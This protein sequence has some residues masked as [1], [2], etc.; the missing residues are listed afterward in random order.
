MSISPRITQLH[1]A[2]LND[3]THNSAE[4]VIA[5]LDERCEGSWIQLTATQDGSFTVVNSRN[6]FSKSYRK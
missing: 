6:G 3:K 2:L 1:R 5:N 4:A